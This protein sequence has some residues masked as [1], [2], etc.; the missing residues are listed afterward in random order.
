MAYTKTDWV[1]GTSPAVNATNLNKIE[2]QLEFL[3][4][5]KGAN[6]V[7]LDTSGGNRS[8][9]TTNYVFIDSNF[10]ATLNVA[11][12][13][14]V[15]LFLKVG[16]VWNTNLGYG[17]GF[18][19]DMDGVRYPDNGAQVIAPVNWSGNFSADGTSRVCETLVFIFKNVT[20][21]THTFKPVWSSTNNNVTSNIGQYGTVFLTAIEL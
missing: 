4:E 13:E 6:A 3:S 5:A 8:I 20:P 9:A 12:G 14:T 7:Q 18:S 1:N 15:L 17:I 16:S 10:G 19:I 11:Q 2:D 21:G